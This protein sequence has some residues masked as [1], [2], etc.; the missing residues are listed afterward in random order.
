MGLIS[1]WQNRRAKE[2]K[3]THDELSAEF[4]E[5]HETLKKQFYE[6]KEIISKRLD[7][8]IVFA[9]RNHFYETYQKFSKVLDALISLD[10]RW[11]D[12][13]SKMGFLFGRGI[14][15][16]LK[17]ENNFNYDKALN[18]LNMMEKALDAIESPLSDL[19]LSSAA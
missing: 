5:T 6:L 15:Y 17:Y 13:D 1:W 2:L 10:R 12:I 7:R 11:Q 14:L 8:K 9:K 3:I 18:T 19:R 16:L 4:F